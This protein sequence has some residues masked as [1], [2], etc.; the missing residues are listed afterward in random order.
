MSIYI[1]HGKVGQARGF[2]KH[3]MCAKW[4]IGAIFALDNRAGPYFL[5]AIKNQKKSLQITELQVASRES[6]LRKT[7]LPWLQSLC[8]EGEQHALH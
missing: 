6:D 2:F 1:T 7:P 4:D 5:F 3:Q 8:Q